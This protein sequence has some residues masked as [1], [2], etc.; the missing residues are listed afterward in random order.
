MRRLG[1]L[2]GTFDPIH[3]GH[4]ALAREAILR[5]GLDGVI[6]LPM[7]RPAHREAEASPEDRLALCRLAAEQ[8]QKIIVSQAGM[9]PGVHFSADTLGP[10]RREFPDAA[11]TLMIGADKLLSLP[12]WR[13]AD[14]LF[15]Q[16]DFLCFPRAG[17]DVQEAMAHAQAVHARV[18]L[19]DVPRVPYS[20]SLIRAQTAAYEDA[21]GLD[22]RVLCR[23]AEKG[24]YQQDFEPQLRGMMSAHRFQHT[25][26]VRK[27]AVR[28]AALH[29]LPIQRAA[30]AGLLHD[31]AKGMPVPD[32]ARVA[33]EHQLVED[34]GM[35]SSGAMLHGPVGAW[36]AQ[37]RFGIRDE[38]VLSAIRSHTIGRP[39]MTGLELCIFVA[40][41]TEENREEYPG[42][43]QLRALAP[44]SLPAAALYSIR[45]TQAYLARTNR[46]FFPIVEE[47]MRYLDSIMTPKEKQWLAAMEA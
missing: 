3:Q 2:G 5:E 27:E 21:P 42:L 26:G 23:M 16:C 9:A 28:L 35:L 31:C 1:V 10:L 34:A 14:Q 6:L 39:G 24:L 19:L 30:L 18:K 41:A 43:S 38:E 7:A 11:L 32:M 17:V 44:V 45:L 47:T 46:P 4:I 20:A 33:R 25:L 12:Y 13:N 29:H 22:P 36:L 15:S 40:D 37:Q 8:E